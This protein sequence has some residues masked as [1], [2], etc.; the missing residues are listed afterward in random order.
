[1]TTER[2]L[3][4]GL[5]KSI[6]EKHRQANPWLNRDVINNYKRQKERLNQPL[7]SI[8]ISF[9]T[10]NLSDLTDAESENVVA[11]LALTAIENIDADIT[12]KKDGRPKGSTK[13]SKHSDI[14]RLQ[15]ALNN[16]ATESFS[17]KEDAFKNGNSCP[18][19]CNA[20]TLNCFLINSMISSS[21]LLDNVIEWK[22]KHKITGDDDN[23]HRLGM[24]YWHN[25]KKCHPE[26]N[27][28]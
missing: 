4:Y 12:I 1:V 24:K 17:I 27:T 21:N 23:K 8:N 14:R 16:A 19:G 15:L 5:S 10:D 7:A 25:F 2:K 20:T 22:E 9:K 18:T 6:L 3:S 13:E 11:V 28:N 26:I